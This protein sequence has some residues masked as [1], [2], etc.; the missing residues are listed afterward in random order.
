MHDGFKVKVFNIV[1]YEWSEESD[2][3]HNVDVIPMLKINIY[4]ILIFCPNILE[5]YGDWNIIY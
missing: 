5:T 4:C 1:L 2:K 3:L